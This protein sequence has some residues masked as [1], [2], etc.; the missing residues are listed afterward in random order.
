MALQ[1]LKK[2]VARNQTNMGMSRTEAILTIVGGILVII[3]IRVIIR[4]IFPDDIIINIPDP[5]P[6]AIANLI[7][8]QLCLNNKQVY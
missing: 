6:D 8:H 1:G 3:I 2:Y 7:L 5:G 4:D